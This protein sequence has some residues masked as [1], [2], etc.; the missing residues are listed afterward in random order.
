MFFLALGKT[1][2]FVYTSKGR[3]TGSSK[4]PTNTIRL[5]HIIVHFSDNYQI[6]MY[7]QGALA[8][9]R[10]WPAQWRLVHISEHWCKFS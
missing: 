5:K 7:L 6:M 1:P 10:A 9:G 4:N 8:L 3:F 2:L